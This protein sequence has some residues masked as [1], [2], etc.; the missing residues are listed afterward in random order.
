MRHFGGIISVLFLISLLSHADDQVFLSR[1]DKPVIIH[2]SET[3]LIRYARGVEDLKIF[4]SDEVTAVL[5]HSETGQVFF[6]PL[7][8]MKPQTAYYQ[9]AWA[10]G[11]SS[12]PLPVEVYIIPQK[13]SPKTKRQAKAK[14]KSRKMAIS[15]FYARRSDFGLFFEVYDSKEEA[16]LAQQLREEMAKP[17]VREQRKEIVI[18]QTLL[19]VR[20]SGEV[21]ANQTQGDL[22]DSFM[23]Q[24]NRSGEVSSSLKLVFEKEQRRRQ[25]L[26]EKA[27][28]WSSA[29]RTENEEKTKALTLSAF[30]S[31][32][33]KK[34]TQASSLFL[35][36]SDLSPHSELVYRHYGVSLHRAGQFELS[37]VVLAL[38][39][40]DT[41]AAAL[42]WF[43]QGLNHFKLKQWESAIVFF[44]KVT[45]VK[46]SAHRV[47]ASFYLGMAQQAIGEYDLA[48]NSFQYVLDH[49]KDPEMDLWAE[50]YINDGL[51][52]KKLKE[53]RKKRFSYQ[54]VLGLIYDSNIVLATDIQTNQATDQEGVRLLSSNTFKYDVYKG[55]VDQ[56]GLRAQASLLQSQKTDLSAS[57]ALE[58]A[59]PWVFS[60]D[61]PWVHQGRWGSKSYSIEFAPKYEVVTMDL[62]NTVRKDIIHSSI[63]NVNNKLVISKDWIG[64]MNIQ[65]RNDDANGASG[66][67]TDDADAFKSM[68][69]LGSLFVLNKERERYFIPSLNYSVNDAKGADFKYKRVD[70]NLLYTQALFDKLVWNNSL[71]FYQADYGSIRKDDNLSVGTGVSYKMGVH[72]KLN[73]QLSYQNND[74]NTNPYEKYQGILTLGFGY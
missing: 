20:Q 36:A 8:K 62:D 68:V 16:L 14:L 53:S 29:K 70:L 57:P 66:T 24:A 54:G 35:Q 18:P 40:T 12:V 64:L 25:E 34:F 19:D 55:E 22:I 2:P 59:D 50:K 37:N 21:R 5:R 7:R 67:I 27:R 31:L 42:V 51:R 58:A 17:L 13:L 3:A 69:T 73:F 9:G 47:K 6:V 26:L 4:G 45:E 44:K 10:Q 32:K 71:G 28:F 52:K 60:L 49:S 43:Y 65:L 63:I 1:Q 30:E 74:S 56:V 72:T 41:E 38:V 61:V 23:T 33:D 46:E 15:P 39:A 11:T 48:R